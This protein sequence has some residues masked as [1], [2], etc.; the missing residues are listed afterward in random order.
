[1]SWHSVAALERLE[2][3][4]SF[5]DGFGRAV[6]REGTTIEVG[7]KA[8]AFSAFRAASDAPGANAAGSTLQ[9]MSRIVPTLGGD[10]VI[11]G[12]EVTRGM[13]D[14]KIKNFLFKISISQGE[15]R[16]IGEID[17]FG[18]AFRPGAPAPVVA[19]Q[20]D[21]VLRRLRVELHGAPYVPIAGT[22]LL[23]V[24]AR[25]A[26]GFSVLVCRG[27]GEK[28]NQCSLS[29]REKMSLMNCTFFLYK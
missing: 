4:D 7:I 2:E 28:P 3:P 12:G 11:E 23:R 26:L 17:G 19:G 15:T 13:S 29:V 16:K 8:Q 24:I 27:P 5:G 21:V 20:G 10:G 9:S 1:M 14:E 22:Q 18:A 25:L 6:E